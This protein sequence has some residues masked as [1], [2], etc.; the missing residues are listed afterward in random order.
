MPTSVNDA[1]SRGIPHH[2]HVSC[3]P[4]VELDAHLVADAAG[5]VAQRSPGR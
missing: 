1:P 2:G 3:R 5:V 4:W